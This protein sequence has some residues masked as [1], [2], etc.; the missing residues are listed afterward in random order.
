MQTSRPSR[1]KNTARL[2]AR[3][4]LPHPPFE[5]KT[6]TWRIGSVVVIFPK[7][8]TRR[9]FTQAPAHPA[10]AT[11]RCLGYARAYAHRVFKDAG[12]GQRFFG[13]RCP[14]GVRERTPGFGKISRA[15]RSAYR[16][17]IRSGADA[18]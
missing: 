13:L 7:G 18:G 6:M 5:F 1:A 10:L 8:K 16:H 15:G 4:L 2:V 3:V 9:P 11:T 17:R 12:A 14:A